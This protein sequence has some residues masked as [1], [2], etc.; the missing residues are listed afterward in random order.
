MK[1]KREFNIQ[2]LVSGVRGY[3]LIEVLAAIAIFF[4]LVASP[5]GV[6]IASLRGQ[7][8]AL[9]LREIADT[10]S[11]ALEYVSRALRMARKELNCTDKT[12]PAT[13]FCL[14]NNGYGF[15]Y[16]IT[17]GGKGI[18]FN[19]YQEPSI[20]QE[21]FWDINDNRLKESKDG[22]SPISLTSDDLEIASL[23]FQLSGSGQGDSLQPRVT[24][25]SKIAKK[26]QPEVKIIIQT[27]ISQRNLDVIY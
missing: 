3:T 2:R 19:N 10:S 5:T 25:L 7:T 24:I 6:F 21:F 17:R 11:Y 18:K 9:A 20:C 1:F 12:N 26:G 14:K 22:A 8:R 16:E 27:T 23:K 4:I 13:C 15:N